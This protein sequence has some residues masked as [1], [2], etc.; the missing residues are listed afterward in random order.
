M[1]DTNFFHSAILFAISQI[2]ASLQG[3]EQNLPPPLQ[4]AVP[5]A[6][7]V[8]PEDLQ[9]PELELFQMDEAN[10]VSSLVS[11]AMKKHEKYPLSNEKMLKQQFFVNRKYHASVLFAVL[12]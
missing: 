4:V 10:L 5:A 3:T 12:K 11:D 1:Q 8:S 2:D 9:E 7:N 6:S